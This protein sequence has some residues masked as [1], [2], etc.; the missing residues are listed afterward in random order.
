MVVYE[1]NIRIF[2]QKGLFPQGF[3]CDITSFTIKEGAGCGIQMF[4]SDNEM[5]ETTPLNHF[6]FRQKKEKT[7]R[8]IFF[9]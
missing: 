6:F 9:C 7:K 8:A 5:T 1:A 2:I 4:L 3:F